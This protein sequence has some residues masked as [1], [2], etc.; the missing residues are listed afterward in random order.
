MAVDTFMW[1]KKGGGKGEDIEGESLDSVYKKAFEI[2]EFSFEVE[3]ATTI[4]SATSGAGVG[5][6][7]FNE[8]TIKKNVDSA[9]MKFFL[10]CC[11]GTHYEQVVIAVRKAGAEGGTSATAG[12]AYMMFTFQTVFT[13]KISYSNDEEKGPQ[14]E[15]TFVYGELGII[16]AKQK[17]AGD[18]DTPQNFCWSQLS[19]KASEKPPLELG[20]T[21]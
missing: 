6:T 5:K 2:P 21:P 19:N 11:T 10:N 15:I 14:E 12:K 18:L 9:S 7:K 13:T 1:F 3:N 4:G 16:Y 20:A 17:P 8:F